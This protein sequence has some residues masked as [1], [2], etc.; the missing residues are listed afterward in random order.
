MIW[1]PDS[2]IPF[3]RT[4]KL[5]D[6]QPNRDVRSMVG[7]APK[8]NVVLSRV[9]GNSHISIL[10]RELN[11]NEIVPESCCAMESRIS[12]CAATRNIQYGNTQC[13]NLDFTHY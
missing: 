8:P 3:T 4:R 13:R 1:T 5:L 2:P 6:N 12:Q 10:L 7:E 9:P 11:E